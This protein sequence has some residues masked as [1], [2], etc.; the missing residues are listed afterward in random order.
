MRLTFLGE[1]GIYDAEDQTIRF[2][3]LTASRHIRFY[4]TEYALLYMANKRDGRPKELVELFSAYRQQIEAIA[5]TK[6][7][8]PFAEGKEDGTVIDIDDI[9]AYRSSIS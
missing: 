2:I 6:Y 5:I 7:Y 4:I 3:G 8:S 1:T 9:A